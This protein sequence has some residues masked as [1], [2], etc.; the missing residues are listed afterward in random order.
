MIQ[1]LRVAHRRTFLALAFVLPLVLLVGLGARRQSSP[2][3]AELPAPFHLV[4]SKGE[5]WKKPGL[6]AA[7]YTN[8]EDPSQIYLAVPAVE[9]TDP[10]VLLYWSHQDGSNSLS[11]DAQLLGPL[12]PGHPFPLDS[13]LKSGYLVLYSL[14]HQKV[15]GVANLEKM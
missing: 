11:A 15:V 10:D 6:Q 14:A 1:P 5:F 7:L 12:A 3:S 13:N 9:L 2:N 4:K 8:T